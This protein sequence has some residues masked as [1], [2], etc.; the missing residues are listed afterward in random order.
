MKRI[1]FFL[2]L[3]LISIH[4]HAVLN[5]KNLEHTLSVLRIELATTYHDL[6]Q[7]TALLK[8]SSEKQHQRMIETMQKSNQIALMLYSQKTSY[9]F[10][11][12]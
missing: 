9:T 7:S 8:A 12:T 4:T 5:E 11:L 2:F 3:Y 10:N 1:L 6:K